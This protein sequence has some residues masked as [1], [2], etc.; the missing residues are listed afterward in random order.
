MF[1]DRF[2]DHVAL[3]FERDTLET[4]DVDE[5]R[6][7]GSSPIVRTKRDDRRNR[8]RN[9]ER[10]FVHRSASRLDPSARA[11]EMPCAVACRSPDSP[12]SPHARPSVRAASYWMRSSSS[13]E[14]G[15]F[16]A[17]LASIGDGGSYAA[18]DVKAGCLLPQ[19][20]IIA[21]QVRPDRQ[22]ARHPPPSLPPSPCRDSRTTGKAAPASRRTRVPR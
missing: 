7:D 8:R 3:K 11:S 16:I 15:W 6:G 10:A 18:A 17:V 5:S 20:A 4:I 9:R 2:L 21:L 13:S 22:V 1:E 14:P 12:R 19:I